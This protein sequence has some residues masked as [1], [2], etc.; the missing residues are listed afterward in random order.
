MKYTLTCCST[1][2]TTRKCGRHLTSTLLALSLLCLAGSEQLRAQEE[3]QPV[4]L[5][6]ASGATLTGIDFLDDR[7]GYISGYEGDG[8][9]STLVVAWRTTDGGGTWRKIDLHALPYFNATFF[10]ETV[11]AGY[12]WDEECSCPIVGYTSDGGETWQ[13]EHRSDMK[14]GFGVERVEG[15]TAYMT[16]GTVDS[17]VGLITSDGGA[18]WSRYGEGTLPIGF[19]MR[20]VLTD[21]VWF[22]FSGH[23]VVKSVDRGLTWSV[24]P[25]PPL[26][27][28]GRI[29]DIHFFDESTGLI[30][31]AKGGPYPEIY[32]TTDGG[33][34]WEQVYAS[35]SYPYE[36]DNLA[37]I[38][39]QTGFAMAGDGVVVITT[40]AGKTWE[41][42]QKIG[43]ILDL[44][45]RGETVWAVGE[46]GR[47]Q[48]RS[49]SAWEQVP[50]HI[51]PDLESVAFG[52]VLLGTSDE[53]S[54]EIANT[55]GADLEITDIRLQ[56]SAGELEITQSPN[57][58]LSFMP[59]LSIRVELRYAP[60]EKGVLD[61]ELLIES[62]D[63][64]MPTLRIPISGIATDQITSVDFR[65][66]GVTEMRGLPNPIGEEGE[67]SLRLE[68]PISGR[69]EIYN[70]QGER[71]ATLHSGELSAGE[72]R[73]RLD[74]PTGSYRCMLT[75]HGTVIA[76]CTL[77][78]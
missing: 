40:D 17:T 20:Q 7:V 52:Q 29:N 59:G 57:L 27:G 45:R 13:T 8:I 33:T 38:D 37:F 61:A 21:D 34:T 41:V 62:N 44:T 2:S 24:I 5:P 73:F 1:G 69:L 9:T 50:P 46:S 14:W 10:S 71:V 72:H 53:I 15:M 18:T 6:E 60:V 19:I 75:D 67:L 16:G 51:D 4:T 32:R 78:R 11:G 74:L 77:L 58:P 30:G 56:E 65:Q 3:W 70:L 63:P 23:S 26:T 39:E 47:L 43:P 76:V 31:L 35:P 22:G 68:R 12:G 64:D 36:M 54:V 66:G 25:V 28:T 55:G 42:D 49:A 48:R